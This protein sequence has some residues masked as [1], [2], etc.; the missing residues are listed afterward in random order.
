MSFEETISESTAEELK[1]ILSCYVKTPATK[2]A[3]DEITS[4]TL[5]LLK[6]ELPP[7]LRCTICGSFTVLDEAVFVEQD[8]QQ[9]TMLI[10][11]LRCKNPNCLSHQRS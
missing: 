2:R 7:V 10:V 1:K 6:P 5:S 11:G 4:L 8:P 3:F 9:P